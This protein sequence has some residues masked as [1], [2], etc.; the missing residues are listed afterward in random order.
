MSR[1][2]TE[3]LLSDIKKIL[4]AN[5]NTK[6]S[7][8]EAEKIAAGFPATQLAAVDTTN[9][10]FEQNWSDAI[11]NIK[12]AIFFG[13]EDIRAQGM[14][15]TTQET[16]QVFVEVILVS[17]QTDTLDKNRIHRYARAIK[18]VFEENYDKIPGTIKIETVRPVSFRLDLNSSD[19]I[20]VGGVSI[21]T[22]LA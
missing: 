18:E 8:V 9:G 13:L 19:E 17:A 5:L 20:K 21:T 12:P 11:L 1:Y 2:D 7:A 15:P 14:G 10:Y 4:V 6:I 22:A 16:Y 3:S